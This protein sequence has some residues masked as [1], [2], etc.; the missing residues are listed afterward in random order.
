MKTFIDKYKDH[1]TILIA[2]IALVFSGISF[3]RSCSSETKLEKINY[4]I[5]AI[6][7]RPKIK[8]SNP[9]IQS[10]KFSSDSILP[11]NPENTDSIG[12]V[13][14]K[15]ELK[16]K[17]NATNIGNT[18]SKIIGWIIADTI[19][20][21][22]FLKDIIKNRRVVDSNTTNDLK[23]PHFYQEL[24]PFDSC[25]LELNYSPQWIEKNKFVIHV[26]LLYENELNQLFDTY[27]WLTVQTKE[28][29]LPNPF[30][31]RNNP[32][33]LKEFKRGIFEIVNIGDENNYSETYTE[34]ERKELIE[35]IE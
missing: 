9:Q 30:Y 13:Y 20:N 21:S 11:N 24:N 5:S 2:L 26:L 35:K 32:E 15:L 23:L 22:P 27:Y 6:E 29:L 16:I 10:F 14:G 1:L 7:Y 19:S 4:S 28:S 25:S 31:F 17:L 12:N 34:K 18:S 3:F 8:L 33:K